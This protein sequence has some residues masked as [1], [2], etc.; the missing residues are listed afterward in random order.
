MEMQWPDWKEPGL[1]FFEWKSEAQVYPF[2]VQRD[3]RIHPVVSGN[4]SRKLRGWL[5]T[6]FQESYEGIVTFGGA[7]SNHLIATACVCYDMKIPCTGLVRGDEG[8]RNRYL[9]FCVAKGM[10]LI[11]VSRSAYR[12]KQ[13]LTD[14]FK[15]H[16]GRRNL[17]IPE[18]GRGELGLSGFE[19]LVRSWKGE[20]PDV[21]V[22]ASATGTTAAGLAR[23][24]RNAGAKTRVLA[25][26]VLRNEAEQMESLREWGVFDEVELIFDY[27]FGGYAK[28]PTSLLDFL[29]E[30]RAQLD[31]PLEPVYTG[32]A[33]YALVHRILPENVGKR[34]CF[35][36]T[37]GIMNYEL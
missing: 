16:F 33:F 18:G 19:E 1:D 7:F 28:M 29:G 32:K 6:Y 26:L 25:V 5:Q 34:V 35:L 2:S 12:E 10:E 3:D 36:H 37:G 23:A 17:V 24:L 20:F 27:H 8:V 9:D 30:A 15:D 11:Y 22:H 13:F 4:K 21:L 14:N 31:L